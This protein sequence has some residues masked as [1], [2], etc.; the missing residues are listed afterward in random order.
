MNDGE[1]CDRGQ[2]PTRVTIGGP[3]G[4]AT[5]AISSARISHQRYP[6]TRGRLTRRAVLVALLAAAVAPAR[7]RAAPA[8]ASLPQTE[9]DRLAELQVKL[10]WG[11]I[12][13][14]APA[15][16]PTI[17]PASLAVVLRV[18]CEGADAGMKT[19]IVKV[20][21]FEGAQADDSLNALWD[22]RKS[23]A[24]LDPS[25]FVSKDRLCF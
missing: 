1:A 4:R 2:S 5:L 20:L 7:T 12:S 10:S 16:D 8:A 18:L 21:G 19:A 9:L 13:G 17:S 14:L 22:A 24:A 6:A 11:L 25:V 23:F 15:G 3:R